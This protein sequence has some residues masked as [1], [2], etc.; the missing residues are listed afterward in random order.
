MDFHIGFPAFLPH[1]LISVFILIVNSFNFHWITSLKRISQFVSQWNTLIPDIYK[2]YLPHPHHLKVF[3]VEN[4]WSIVNFVD[5]IMN[6]KCLESFFVFF[7][8]LLLP[9]HIVNL[10]K[11]RIF[12]SFK[13]VAAMPHIMNLNL[14][15]SFCPLKLV[16]KFCCPLK[17]LE[18][19][20]NCCYYLNIGWV[21]PG[22]SH[23]ILK[24]LLI[25]DLNFININLRC[26]MWRQ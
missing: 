19:F 22:S 6:L 5:H 26:T 24:F 23:C 1:H 20:F 2:A 25:N 3:K 13:V 16:W 9:P 8:K 11:V 10:N 12:L 7:S 18:S 14:L 4:S 17:C 21:L 15:E